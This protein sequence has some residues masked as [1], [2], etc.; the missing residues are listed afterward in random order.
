[1]QFLIHQQ[2]NILSSAILLLLGLY[3]SSVLDKKYA[4]NRIYFIS[5][6]LN[7]ALIL[8]EVLL[9]FL[10]GFKESGYLLTEI[11]GFLLFTLSPVLPYL[12]LRFIC[13]YFPSPIKIKKSVS[14]VLA[15]LFIINLI[16]AV[17]SFKSKVFE[18]ETVADGL[19][20]FLATIVFLVY[21]LYVIVKN[22]KM[23]LK[24]EYI[25]ILVIGLITNILVLS[26]LFM[27]QTR[28][29]WGGSTFTIIMMFI[30]I[31]Q[32][33]LYRDSL[34]GAR[35]RLVLKKCLDY[36]SKNSIENLSIIM[37]DLDH[38]KKI[39]DVYGHSEGD[40]ALKT[41]VKL[42]QRVYSDRGIVIRMGGD[43]FIVLLYELS[44]SEIN[45]LIKKMEA[46][47]DRYNIKCGKPY[48]IKYS[49]ASGTYNNS[50]SVDQFIHDIDMK[51]YQNKSGRRE[52]IERIWN[53]E[54]L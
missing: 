46:A 49:C 28:F 9:H 16:V 20:P 10:I 30:V 40:S 47:V 38:F 51:M 17:F 29:I 1:M 50:I 33:E 14:A 52:R 22:R 5:L 32:R 19:M 31:Q 8:L 43:E 6:F 41:F 27:N 3:A 11:A 25:Y 34:T 36:Y 4:I 42:L 13:S 24:F 45:E 26:Q 23:L 39:N 53:I 2:M 35:N 15:L 37:M 54:N 48:G 7:M 18:T 21:S 44:K 12:F